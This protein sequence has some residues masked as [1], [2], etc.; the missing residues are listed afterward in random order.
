MR[1]ATRVK[2]AWGLLA[3]SV[4]GWPLTALTLARDEPFFILSLSW[5]AIILTA[6]DILNTSD[7]RRRQDDD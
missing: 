4:I 7:V 6:W 1:P 3:C 5:L 2:L